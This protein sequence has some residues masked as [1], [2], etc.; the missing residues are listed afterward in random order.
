MFQ[1]HWLLKELEMRL[2]LLFKNTCSCH[3]K[4]REYSYIIWCGAQ[5]GEWNLQQQML[6]VLFI[7]RLFNDILR[8]SRYTETDDRINNKFEKKLGKS[9]G[10]I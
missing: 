10:L 4:L 3:T 9:R 7:Y 1:F 2:S 6:I 5:E 8:T